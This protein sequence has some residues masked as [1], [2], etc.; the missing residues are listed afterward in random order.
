MAVLCFTGVYAQSNSQEEIQDQQVDTESE[1]QDKANIPRQ[2][3]DL[4]DSIDE[5]F[6]PSEELS[7]GSAATFPTDI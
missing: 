1:Q 4:A 6:I 2:P 3:S 7:E 5:T